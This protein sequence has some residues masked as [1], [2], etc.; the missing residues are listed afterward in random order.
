MSAFLSPRATATGHHG[1]LRP[2]AADAGPAH[3]GCGRP[4]RHW[5]EPPAT[6]EVPAW[7]RARSRRPGLLEG[8]LPVARP[9]HTWGLL[10]GAGLG[11]RRSPRPGM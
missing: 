8:I 7:S 4:A 2:H 6:R 11:W 5:H 3:P 1:P 9:L 10:L